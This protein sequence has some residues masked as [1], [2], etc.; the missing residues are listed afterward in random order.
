MI[1]AKNF[2]RDQNNPGAIVNTDINSLKAYRAKREEKTEINNLKKEV[3]EIKSLL[4]QLIESN[5]NK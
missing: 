2:R 1:I 4:L 5:K 3:S